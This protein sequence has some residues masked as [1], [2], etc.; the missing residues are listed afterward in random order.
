MGSQYAAAKEVL[1]GLQES[2]ATVIYNLSDDDLRIAESDTISFF[3]SGLKAIGKPGPEED[4]PYWKIEQMRQ[5]P[6]W[7][8][9]L[10][11]QTNVVLPYCLRTGRSLRTADEMAAA[12]DGAVRADEYLILHDA[13]QKLQRGEEVG[14][15]A[16]YVDVDK[17]QNS[18]SLLIT[19]NVNLRIDDAS[20]QQYV[21]WVRHNLNFSSAPRYVDHMATPMRGISQRAANGQDTPDMLVTQINQEAVAVDLGETVVTSTGG[22]NN[23]S[24]FLDTK[25]TRTAP[26]D[27]SRRQFATR[28]RQ[29]LPNA[30]QVEF[31]P[32]G[33]RKTTIFNE[34]LMDKA[35]SLGDPIW[36]AVNSDWQT[37]SP[38]ARP[39]YQV[40]WMDIVHQRLEV[41][42]VA[43]IWTGDIV[44]GDIYPDFKHESQAIG[45][46]GLDAQKEFVRDM[47]AL[48][49][50]EVPAEYL[51]N[52]VSEDITA[53]NH[54]WHNGAIKGSGDSVL[55]YLVMASDLSF[56]RQGLDPRAKM[57]N[58]LQTPYGEPLKSY[59]IVRQLG[60]YGIV[61]RHFA[62]ERGSTKGASGVPIYAAAMQLEG[63][64]EL[65]ANTDIHVTGHWHNPEHGV[66]GDKFAKIVGSLAGQSGYEWERAYKAVIGAS[67]IRIGGGLPVQIEDFSEKALRGHV[68]QSG[69]FSN[70]R[71]AEEGFRT[72]E[73][74]DPVRHGVLLGRRS[75]K[76]AEQKKLR[77]MMLDASEGANTTGVFAG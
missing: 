27:P 57:Y 1:D 29:G 75:P 14:E 74:W 35:D 77:M 6:K 56:A 71:L 66:F 58:R 17:L 42:R 24:R 4:I 40:K 69:P 44:H 46:I 54:E 48:A 63:A 37:G 59:T 49:R 64:K 52:I 43:M 10:A 65:S 7:D 18:A 51:D 13:W 47:I 76:S 53:G 20:G 12:T 30:V 68:I 34:T 61:A 26:G 36:L 41:G 55:D 32:Y 16:E 70:E 22:F 19:D 72:D 60:A 39:D 45:L 38:T 67:M 28:R 25:G 9:H 73:G 62:L 50:S 15:F 3:R 23:S 11:F 33:S 21:T 8:E 5:H 2:G 31:T